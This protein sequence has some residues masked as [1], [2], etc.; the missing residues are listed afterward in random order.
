M[1]GTISLW[2]FDPDAIVFNFCCKS[3]LNR[4]TVELML[5]GAHIE[6]PAVPGTGYDAAGEL[7]FGER[8]T[9]MRA[10]TVE[11]KEFTI[12]IEEG[13]YALIRDGFY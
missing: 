6:R 13:Y 1:A 11:R 3:R 12:D 2:D 4:V 5:T 8:P 9:L 10:D 7:A